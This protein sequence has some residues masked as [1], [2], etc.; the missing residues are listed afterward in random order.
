MED[1]A[2]ADVDRSSVQGTLTDVRLVYALIKSSAVLIISP[3]LGHCLHLSIR[4][5][6]RERLSARAHT[7]LFLTFW[8]SAR[9]M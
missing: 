9:P 8:I 6:E 3:P 1:G 7:K 4:G 2:I 5:V